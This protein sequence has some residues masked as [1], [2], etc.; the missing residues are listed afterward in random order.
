MKVETAGS[1]VTF[2]IGIFFTGFFFG[3]GAV[4]EVTVLADFFST[5]V[6]LKAR[7]PERRLTRKIDFNLIAVWLAAVFTSGLLQSVNRRARRLHFFHGAFDVTGF[8]FN[9]LRGVSKHKN[10]KT[11]L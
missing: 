10:F 2:L 8:D 11:I 7:T 6:A 3:E 9:A 1:S 4:F 5:A